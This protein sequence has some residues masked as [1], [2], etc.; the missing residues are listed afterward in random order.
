MLKVGYELPP[1]ILTNS[2]HYDRQH[3][4][5]YSKT[6]KVNDTIIYTAMNI[7]RFKIVEISSEHPVK[8]ELLCKVFQVESTVLLSCRITRSLYS[9]AESGIEAVKRDLS[10][11]VSRLILLQLLGQVSSLVPLLKHM[12]ISAAWYSCCTINVFCSTACKIKKCCGTIA[13]DR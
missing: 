2:S 4:M 10:N 8:G 12:K 5:Q 3:L 13:T 9:I 7:V 6:M 1:S 11:D